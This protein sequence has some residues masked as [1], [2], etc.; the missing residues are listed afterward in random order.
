M[1]VQR[2]FIVRGSLFGTMGFHML[3]PFFSALK[4]ALFP[5]RCLG[6]GAIFHPSSG[7]VGGVTVNT[8]PAPDPVQA[9]S[10]EKLM[11]PFL[12]ST[13][14]GGYLPVLPPLC[15]VCGL[16]FSGRVGENHLCED[17][18]RN[19]RPFRMARAAGIYEAS[20]RTVIHRLKYG[21]KIQLAGPL[22]R[23]LLATFFRFW[24]KDSVDMVVPVPLHIK[25]FR[26]RGFN[27]AYVLIRKWAG[28]LE[29][30]ADR[31]AAIEITRRVLARNRRTRPQTGLGRMGRIENI[32]HAFSLTGAV[33]VTDR[34][35]LL[36]DDVM[37]TGATVAECT[38]VL[39]EGGAR[40]VDVLALARAA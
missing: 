32:K 36:V 13:C 12:C 2:S 21:G 34:R 16:V 1:N 38:K 24:E 3:D 8:V 40:Y 17:C 28:L 37:T 27:Q 14:I 23:L 15:P 20:L 5:A 29:E 10:F 7:S 18:M 33:D 30:T 26:Q 39:I 35:I 4:A 6:C 11:P 22:G 9:S 25:R 31:P 19:P